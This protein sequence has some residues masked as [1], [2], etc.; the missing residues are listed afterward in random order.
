LWNGVELPSGA[1]WDPRNPWFELWDE[2]GRLVRRYW[3]FTENRLDRVPAAP[4]RGSDTLSVFH[5]SADIPLRVY[6]TP[7]PVSGGDW[8]I[9]VMR[10][11]EPSGDALGAL[12]LIR[13]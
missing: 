3:P 8:M 7:F 10:I 2:E 11:H 6:S 9:R 1:D 13:Q 12:L 4:V 5:I